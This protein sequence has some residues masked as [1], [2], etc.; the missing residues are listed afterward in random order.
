[1]AIGSLAEHFM[2]GIFR[3]AGP[4]T[5]IKQVGGRAVQKFIQRERQPG[6][7]ADAISSGGSTLKPPEHGITNAVR[8]GALIQSG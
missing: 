3:T 1:M 8:T 2:K 7:L 5:G 4:R 6:Q